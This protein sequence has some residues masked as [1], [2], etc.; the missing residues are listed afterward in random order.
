MAKLLKSIKGNYLFWGIAF[1]LLFIPLYPK[2]P[3]WE[4]PETYV[5]IRLEDVFVAFIVGAFVLRLV[6]KRDFSLL[7]DSLSL[8]LALYFG[9]GLLSLLSA[10]FITKNIIPHLAFLHF[11]RRLEYISLL[12]VA[13]FSFKNLKQLKIYGWLSLVTTFLVIFYGLGQKFLGWPVVSTMNKEFSQGMILKLTWWARIN[14]TF[15]GHYDLAAYLAMILPLAFAGIMIAKKKA[16]KALILLLAILAYYVL[17]LTASRISFVAYLLS[18]SFVLWFGKKR[19]WLIPFLAFSILGMVFS[20]DLGQRYA[21]TFKIDLSFL[22]GKIKLRPKIASLPSPTPTLITKETATPVPGKPTST[23]TPT[24]TLTPTPVAAESAYPEPESVSLATG[25]STDIR[26]KV[27]WPRA[28]RAFAKNPILGT[29][30]S[31]ITLATD[32]DYL[33]MLGEIGLLGSLALLAVFLEILRRFVVF[34]RK[35]TLRREERLIILGI[36]GASIGYFF[37]AS[38]IDVFE[39]SKIAFFFWI[40]IGVGL[41][42]IDLSRAKKPNA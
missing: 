35:A 40:L 23:P 25:R 9:I 16:A 11:L 34:L 17:I 27:E 13:Y 36:M 42:V 21:A 6:V 1:L 38:F 2:F 24:P 28:L 37:N 33:R 5:H 32:N 14:S 3:L 10:L 4:V 41:R 22:S 26:L 18:V 8:L 12:Y 30:Y 19:W 39:A 31:S 15:A 7:K 29:G 20:D